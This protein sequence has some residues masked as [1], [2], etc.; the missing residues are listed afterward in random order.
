MAVSQP[1]GGPHLLR[2]LRVSKAGAE[3][4]GAGWSSLL[5]LEASQLPFHWKMHVGE[6][7]SQLGVPSAAHDGLRHRQASE[8]SLL[9]SLSVCAPFALLSSSPGEGGLPCEFR[10]V[11]N[12]LCLCSELPTQ[13]PESP[14][15]ADYPHGPGVF[16][17]L[18]LSPRAWKIKNP[19]LPMGAICL[20]VKCEF[21]PRVRR[22]F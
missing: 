8:A 16:L 7:E 2:Y 15:H 19:P 12:F 1:E 4:L 9:P 3:I 11:H 5:S 6:G 10:S 21:N 13:L 20:Y 22:P 17:S 14:R 18:W